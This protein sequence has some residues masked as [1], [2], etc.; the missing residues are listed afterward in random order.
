MKSYIIKIKVQNYKINARISDE[1]VLKFTN[2]GISKII[3]KIKFVN[4]RTSEIH[5]FYN[6]QLFYWHFLEILW[7]FFFLV[8]YLFYVINKYKKEPTLTSAY[9]WVSSFLSFLLLKRKTE[10]KTQPRRRN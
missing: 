6:L 7:L 2:F 9:P 8:L 4:L 1:S 5:L 10:K 3:K